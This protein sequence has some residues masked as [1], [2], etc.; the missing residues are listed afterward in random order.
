M[1]SWTCP[2]TK[3]T[4]DKE[5]E[6]GQQCPLCGE[7]AKEFKS[8]ELGNLW[9][10][11]WEFKESIERAKKQEKVLEK[12]KFCPKCGSAHINFL[13]F[14]RPGIWR[15]LDC[16]YEGAFIIEDSKLAEK[17]REHCSKK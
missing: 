8:S 9:R 1:P 10:Q 7:Q 2:N 6:L 16:D 12:V 5:L 14:Y 15:C 11:K 17:I 3:C 4:Y 13:I